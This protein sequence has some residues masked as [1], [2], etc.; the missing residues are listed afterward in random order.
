MTRASTGLV[1]TCSISG[2]TTP[3]AL[4]VAS[5]APRST[6]AVRM[7]SRRRLGDTRL[8]SQR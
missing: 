5:T 1:M 8:G 3:V 6:I 2:T 7:A 4:M